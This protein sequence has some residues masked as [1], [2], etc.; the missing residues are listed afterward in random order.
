ML[1]FSHSPFGGMFGIVFAIVPLLVLA[2]F[3]F[4]FGTIIS[5]TIKNSKQ[6][7]KDNDSPVL[8]VDATVITKRTHVS[9]YRHNR[10]FDEMH[11][12]SSSTEYYATFQ[13]ESGDRL[14]FSVT[15]SEYGMLAENDAGR[16]TFQGSRYL[17]FERQRR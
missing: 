5:N 1:L 9:T 14:E 2:T 12:M 6:R 10:S 4:V 17:S 13:V 11:H 16:L 7:K 15:G 3:A 8:T